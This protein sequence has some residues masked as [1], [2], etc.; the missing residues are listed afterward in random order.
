MSKLKDFALEIEERIKSSYDQGYANGY[1]NGQMDTEYKIYNSH[2][3]NEE[4]ITLKNPVKGG[5]I[6]D[7]RGYENLYDMLKDNII[8]IFHTDNKDELDVMYKLARERLDL[9]YTESKKRVII[10][11]LEDD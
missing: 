8:L 9:L 6:M 2:E 4:K 5:D 10:K 7:D 11:E 1:R 3:I